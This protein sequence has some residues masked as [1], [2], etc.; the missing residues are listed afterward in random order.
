VGSPTPT[1]VKTGEAFMLS[2]RTFQQV[3]EAY[4]TENEYGRKGRTIGYFTDEK[5]AKLAA[6]KMGWYGS[7]GGICQ[8]WALYQDDGWI[9][10]E[11]PELVQLDV[12]MSK[13]K[14][15]AKKAAL[16]KL[17]QEERILLGLEK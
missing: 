17:T 5:K 7:E 11:K 10:V 9:I 16:E 3:W 15:N 4:T 6:A 13:Y 12:D 14:E 1:P 8:R 2:K